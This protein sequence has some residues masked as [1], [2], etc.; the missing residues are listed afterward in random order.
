MGAA[1]VSRYSDVVKDL[2]NVKADLAVDP[3]T[4]MYSIGIDLE[5][6]GFKGLGVGRRVLER[7]GPMDG[8][9]VLIF[10]AKPAGAPIIHFDGPWQVTFYAEKPVLKL[11]RDNDVVL[12]VGTPGQ[13]PGT[14]AMLFYEET[15]PAAVIPRVEVMLPAAQANAPPLKEVFELKQRC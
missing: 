11:H 6:P 2:P 4:L 7:G 5:K 14:F 15:I 1:A 9:G 13:G 3:K 12:V 10:A 8:N